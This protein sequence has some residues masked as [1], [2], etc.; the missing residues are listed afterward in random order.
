MLHLNNFHNTL[1]NPE[2]SVKSYKHVLNGCKS[3]NMSAM[4]DYDGL[5]L[6]ADVLLLACVFQNFVKDSINS[7]PSYVSSWL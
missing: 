3:F 1:N 5:C 2:I 6:K 4:N 7:F